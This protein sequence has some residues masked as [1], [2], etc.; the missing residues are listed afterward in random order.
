MA[1]NLKILNALFLYV[2]DRPVRTEPIP[3]PCPR[4]SPSWRENSNLFN[5]ITLISI[6]RQQNRLAGRPPDSGTAA[7]GGR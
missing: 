1:A 6:D 7:G 5:E 2:S 3:N 4:R